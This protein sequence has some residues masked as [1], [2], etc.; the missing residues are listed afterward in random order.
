MSGIEPVILTEPYKI[1]IYDNFSL[2]FLALLLIDYPVLLSDIINWIADGTLCFFNTARFLPDYFKPR[3][4]VNTALGVRTIPSVDSLSE[5]I[6]IVIDILDDIQK[7][8]F[9]YSSVDK[10]FSNLLKYYDVVASD[11][12]F[13]CLGLF[14]RFYFSKNHIFPSD[15]SVAVSFLTSLRLYFQFEEENSDKNVWLSWFR[16]YLQR[17]HQK[18]VVCSMNSSLLAQSN[19]VTE[20]HFLNLTQDEYFERASA[21][22]SQHILVMKSE[23][24]TRELQQMFI[25]NEDK[26]PKHQVTNEPENFRS[27]NPVRRGRKRKIESEKLKPFLRHIIIYPIDKIINE[28]ILPLELE[29]LLE[30][31]AAHFHIDTSHFFKE[32]QRIAKLCE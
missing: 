25:P 6:T 2:I 9:N 5:R 18:K 30:D 19:S 22:T 15:L 26:K 31:I 32:V 28:S 23:V 4:L 20:K 11:V 21:I 1:S 7:P 13:L 17:R 3:R 16:P 27:K 8:L 24:A 12:H 29:I 14:E 10:I